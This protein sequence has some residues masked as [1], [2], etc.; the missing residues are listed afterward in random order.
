MTR[1]SDRRRIGVPILV[2]TLGVMACLVLT[3]CTGE[4]P[5]PG[6]MST[7][8]AGA[9][10]TATTLGAA[11]STA[12]LPGQT[13]TTTT[14]HAM[15][16]TTLGAATSTAA[17]GWDFEDHSNTHANFTKLTAAQISAQEAAVNQA[18]LEHLGFV[19][20]HF[21]YPY[22]VYT[23]T[24]ESTISH[25]R[26]TGRLYGGGMS[27]YPNDN[28]FEMKAEP[29]KRAMTWKTVKGWVDKCIATDSLLHIVTHDSSSR[30]SGY[31]TTPAMLTRF[32][33]YLVAQKAAGRLD[34]LTTAEAYSQ[35]KR[36]A[37]TK[38]TVVVSFDD[39]HESDYLT[40]YPLFHE[41][42]LKGTSYIVTSWVGRPGCLTWAE[43]AAMRSGR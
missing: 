11:T 35:W 34:V 23:T 39:A 15:T 31:G 22:G 7:T 4:S 8:S 21:A 19:P 33:D 38:A 42:G 10:T 14:R 9:V 6:Q 40:V 41:R 37:R 13:P 1:R 30:P 20:Q 24:A 29:L 17:T 32:L 28:W 12:P 5:V 43:I 25:Y 16:T 36:S 27:A 2:I 3:S 26:K 18:F